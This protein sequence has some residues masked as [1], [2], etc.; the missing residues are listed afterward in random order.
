MCIV[1]SIPVLSFCAPPECNTIKSGII[2]DIK[3]HIVQLGYD[4][5]GYNYQA[6]MFNGLYDN[7]SRPTDPVTSG[8]VN[9]IM[10]WSDEWIANV[11]CDGDR[12]LDRGLDVKAPIEPPVN[13]PPLS[14]ANSKG[15]LTNHMEG[16]ST[17]ST[18]EMEHYTYFT[19]IVWVGP[20]GPSDPWAG[21][22]IWGIFAI[23][24]E[25][26]NN[27]PPEGDPGLCGGT[28]GGDRSKLVNPA[29]LGFYTN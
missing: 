14:G 4:Q 2:T 16:A 8:E 29:G 1:L 12:K 25:V 15:W 9:L 22:R 24:E 20:A 17:G 11:D 6:H 10:K 27:A 21:K 18:G 23:I 28:N 13:P 19:K 26:S 7:Y 3:G 5:W